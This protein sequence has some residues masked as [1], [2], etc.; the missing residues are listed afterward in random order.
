MPAESS[1]EGLAAT[2]QV[3]LLTNYALLT[4]TAYS[5]HGCHP[6]AP[7][8]N[9]GTRTCVL[10]G[11]RLGARTRTMTIAFSNAAPL[12]ITRLTQALSLGIS[13]GI[14]LIERTPARALLRM[15]RFKVRPTW[16]PDASSTHHVHRHSRSCWH[17]TCS[18]TPS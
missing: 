12:F 15:P 1:D 5:A 14:A 11:P 17:S 10:L 7:S 18:C 2:M 16:A 9:V 6:A 8:C 13:E 3:G 4:S